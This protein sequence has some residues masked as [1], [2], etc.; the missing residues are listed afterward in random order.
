MA[1]IANCDE[2]LANLPA[3]LDGEVSGELRS[4]VEA[5]LATCRNCRIVVD[6]ANKTVEL[7]RQLPSPVMPQLAMERLYKRLDL[8]RG[9]QPDE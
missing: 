1:T 9:A 5:H 6:T 3:Y 7:V 2:L 4:E 8:D